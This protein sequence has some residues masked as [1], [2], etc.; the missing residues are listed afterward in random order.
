MKYLCLSWY[1]TPPYPISTKH[2]G[3]HTPLSPPFHPS[4][5]SPFTRNSIV[6]YTTTQP[7]PGP[8][9]N[10]KDPHPKHPIA[11]TLTPYS[12]KHPRNLPTTPSTRS[13]LSFHRAF[14]SRFSNVRRR[15]L[16]STVSH[17]IVRTAI[18]SHIRTCFLVAL[19]SELSFSG[20]PSP[21]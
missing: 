1:S 14:L 21:Y 13:F 20:V 4:H 7:N 3:I 17:V 6:R 8:I 12:P 9:P 2:I 10:A 11:A 15:F 5:P 19:S 18:S 16:P